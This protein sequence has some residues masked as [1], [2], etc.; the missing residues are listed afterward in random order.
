MNPKATTKKR[1]Y[2]NRMLLYKLIAILLP[3]GIL[4]ILEFLF[5]IGGYGN[6]LSLFKTDQTG[7]YYYLNPQIGK[8]YFTQEVN[9]TNGNMD[10]FRK[11]KIPGTLRFFV[12]GSSTAIGFPYMYNGAFPR[13]LNYRLQRHFP[14]LN[15]EMINLSLTAINSYAVLDMAK[16]L[17]KYQ[18]DAVLIYAG[19]N[20]Y[21]GTLGVASSSKFGNHP[22]LINLFIR[23]KQSR[24]MQFI[25]NTIYTPKKADASTDLN[26]TLMERLAAGQQIPLGSD[27]YKSGLQQFE[28]NIDKTLDLFTSEKIPVFIG[29]LVTNERGIHPF[30]SNLSNPEITTEWNQLFEKGKISLEKGDTLQA[31]NLFTAANKLDSTFAECQFRLGEIAYAR[32]DFNTAKKLYTNAKELDQLRFRAPDAFNDIIRKIALNRPEIYVT[33]VA[34]AFEL[35][36][37]HHIVGEELL[38]EHVHPNL[39]GYYLLADTYYKSITTSN[40]IPNFRYDTI[41]DEII[42]KQ[43]PLTQF[44]TVYGYVSNILLKENWPFNEPLPP[45]TPAEQTYEG[46]VAGGLAVKQYSWEVAMDKLFNH[47]IK[48]LDFANALRIAEGQCL[49]FPFKVSYFEN[50]AKLAQKQKDDDRALFYLLKIWNIFVRSNEIAQQLVITTLNSDQPQLTIPFLDYLIKNTK[51]NQS[52][53]EQKKQI[54]NIIQLKDKLKLMPGDLSIINKIAALY[55][56]S[57]NYKSAQKYI[58]LSVESDSKS[59]LGKNLQSQVDKMK[60]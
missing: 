3:F 16:E 22:L 39:G 37:P 11:K 41:P 60:Q 18:P 25:Y 32:G 34:T 47:Y 29:T 4:L 30:V 14:E 13:M 23:S 42:R 54:D 53:V 7:K 1:N 45:P 58:D 17:A 44:D 46:K 40:L 52:L 9:A 19:Q 28:R 51:P 35:A 15:I 57:K 36:S 12:L 6:E 33:D 43:M 21:H 10:F 27:K 55:I 31:Y 59:L 26:L 48:N 24:L 56:Q 8:R 50:A 49:E 2:F 38:L 20:E 5:R